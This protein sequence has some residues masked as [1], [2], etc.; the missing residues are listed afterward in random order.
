M[1]LNL[2]EH[3]GK[4][5]SH[6]CQNGFVGSRTNHCAHYVSHALGLDFSYHCKEHT[7]GAGPGANMRVHEVFA[8]CPMVG[9]WQDADPAKTQIIFVTRA[10]HVDVGQKKMVNHPQKHVGIY[11]DGNVYHYSNSRNHVTRQEVQDFFDT[12]QRVYS[13][14]QGLFFGLIPGSDLNL[15]VDLEASRPVPGIAFTIREENRQY[16]AQADGG[17]A[18]LVGRSVPYRGNRGLQHKAGTYY[19]P[20]YKAEQYAGRFDHWATVAE[21]IGHCESKNHFNLINT[22]DAAAFTFGFIQMAAHTPED[23][24][25]LLFRKILQLP[26]AGQYFP[27]LAL[28]DGRVHRVNENG[29]YTNLETP[30]NSR[31]TNLMNYLNPSLDRVDEQ[32]LLHAARMIHWAN[33]SA[34]MREA[35]V[36]VAIEITASKT[37]RRYHRWYNLDGASDVLVTIICDIHHQGRARKSVV[38]AAL[39]SDDPI[40]ALLTVNHRQWKNR[41]DDLK[42]VLEAMVASGALGRKAYD[43]ANN[44]FEDLPSGHTQPRT[45]SRM[46]PRPLDPVRIVPPPIRL[47]P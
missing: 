22:Y 38:Q 34:A 39:E 1:A 10:S 12:F 32:E 20:V 17:A 37:A 2:E 36:E 42:E 11:H 28:R 13:G 7:G 41:N 8:Q 43:A 45:L 27:E 29:S 18:F 15:D 21:A 4:N 3:V 31:L 24:L 33:N 44:V 40:E 30:N 14:H 25:I 23:N 16:R 5:I 26:E 46:Q 9:R 47:R 35:Q 6:F 19:G